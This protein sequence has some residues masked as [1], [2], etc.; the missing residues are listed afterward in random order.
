MSVDGVG[1]QR[2][3]GERESQADS[4]SMEP[5]PHCRAQSHDPEIM[6]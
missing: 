4:M 6:T 5:D 1:R 3:E 2:A